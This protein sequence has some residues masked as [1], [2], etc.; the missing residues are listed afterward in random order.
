MK[1]HEGL[2]DKIGVEYWFHGWKRWQFRQF[3]ELGPSSMRFVRRHVLP[4]ELG[5]RHHEWQRCNW[6]DQRQQQHGEHG[7]QRLLEEVLV[8]EG[9]VLQR[10]VESYLDVQE[11]GRQLERA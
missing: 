10:K 4:R 5:E 9:F 3:L 2:N 1:S 6:L 8:N 7:Q 11:R